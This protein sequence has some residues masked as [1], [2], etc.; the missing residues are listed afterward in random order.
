M[1]PDD[2]VAELVI[3]WIAAVPSVFVVALMLTT[4]GM[5]KAVAVWIAFCIVVCLVTVRCNAIAEEIE[6]R[7]E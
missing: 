3:V 2:L 6:H 7:A 5:R 1:I 4:F